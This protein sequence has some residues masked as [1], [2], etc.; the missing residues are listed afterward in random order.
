M[1][2]SENMIAYAVND[3]SRSAN[4]CAEGR[5]ERDECATQ[6]TWPQTGSQS[7]RETFPLCYTPTKNNFCQYFE[8]RM[9]GTSFVS[10][11]L[12]GV[13]FKT[14]SCAMHKNLACGYFVFV[15]GANV[16]FW[17]LL[18]QIIVF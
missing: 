8:H 12:I 10:K 4:C 2:E 6:S 11:S 9:M 16:I 15:Q 7:D 14:P 5:W 17:V 13:L 18:H 1:K 3:Q